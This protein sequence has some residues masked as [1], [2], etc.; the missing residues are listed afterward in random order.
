[1]DILLLLQKILQFYDSLR[2]IILIE[3]FVKLNITLATIFKK[4]FLIKSYMYVKKNIAIRKI[5]IKYL[6][7][8]HL[9][10]LRQLL[11]NAI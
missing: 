8:L 5:K 4:L 9:Q 7:H 1:M 3:L 2:N 10:Y 11:L 6:E